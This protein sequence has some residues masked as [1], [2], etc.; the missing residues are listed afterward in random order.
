MPQ[1]LD[2]VLAEQDVMLAEEPFTAIAVTA[3][4]SLCALTLLLADSPVALSTDCEAATPHHPLG[5]R[6]FR[7]TCWCC[8]HSEVAEFPFDQCP[9]CRNPSMDWR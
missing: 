3:E 6:T 9:E 1:S 5:G 4:I 2:Q 8:D 7:G